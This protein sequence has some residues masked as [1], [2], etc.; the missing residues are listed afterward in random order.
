MLNIKKFTF[1][2]VEVNTIILWDK[3]LECVLIDPACYYPEEEQQLKQFVESNQLKPVRL[4]N[5]HGH[6]DHLMGNKFIKKTW[7]LKCEIHKDDNYL[8][9]HAETLAQLFGIEMT[10]PPSYGTFIDDGEI[11]SFGNSELKVIHVPGHSPGSVAFY[12][13]ADKILISGDI[14]FYGSIGRT[15]L[16]KG[17]FDLLISGI[18]EKLLVLDGKV[19]V[20]CGHGPDTSIGEEKRNNPYLS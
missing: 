19:K 11:I 5:T 16:P 9:E 6:F 15:D 10:A 7:G 13:E 1:N 2:P 3:T 12:S 18:K 4:L 14:L 17:N 8:I 20:Y